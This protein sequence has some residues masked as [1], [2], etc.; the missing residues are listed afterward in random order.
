M[1]KN[2]I[3][4]STVHTYNP[5]YNRNSYK[6]KAKEKGSS[7]KKKIVSVLLVAAMAV[8]L[9]ACGNSSKSDSTDSS[10]N[11]ESSSE[12][13]ETKKV[14]WAQGASGNVLVSIAKDQGY[15]DEVG[16]EVEEVPLDEGQ[17]EAVRTGQVDIASNSGTMRPLQ[18]IASGDDL[19]IIGGFMLTG[20][21]PVVA[22]E[23]QEWNSPEDFLGSKFADAKSRYCLFHSLV[24][25]GH[26]LD[27]EIE[28]ATYDSDSEKIQAVLK[29]EIDYATIGTGRM[30]EVEHTDGLKIVTY[31]S[32]VTPNYSCCR[33]VAR[34]SWVQENEETVKLID[35]ALIRAM[36][37][38]ESH[39][40]DCVDLMVDQLSANKEYVEAYMLNEHYRINPDTVKNIVVDNY[41]YMVSVGGIEN[42][43]TSVKLEDRIYNNIYKEALDEA[44]EKWGD[45]DKDFYD[46]AVK[47]YQENNE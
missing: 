44:V 42:L 46:N 23:D 45:E 5:E 36:C 38:F 6:K 29:G 15:F 28:F 26:D 25:E 16:V 43:D 2:S 30:Y 10:S 12:S 18:M 4:G 3:N 33:M 32:D 41:N 11:K 34:N 7:M 13:K 24:E 17:L 20:C 47:F 21:M 8:S 35:E 40:E 31:C 37:Y 1:R 27:K 22:R 39:R 19:A 9:V 14:K